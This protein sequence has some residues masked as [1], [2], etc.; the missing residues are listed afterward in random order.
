[1]KKKN[2]PLKW[3]KFLSKQKKKGLYQIKAKFP[4]L[5]NWEIQSQ[6][7][8]D[9][10]SWMDHNTRHKITPDDHLKIIPMKFL[11]DNFNE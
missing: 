5:N 11:G 6:L 3:K 10:K 2:N 1:M 7:I 8:W 4:Y 9:G